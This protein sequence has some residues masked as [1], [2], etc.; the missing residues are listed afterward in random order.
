[1]TDRDTIAPYRWRWLAFAAVLAASV[2][3]LLDST[4]AQVAAPAIRGDLGG[5]YA[6]LQWISAAYSLAMAVVLLTGGR[7]GDIFG[8]RRMLLVGVT[9]FTLSSL[10]G[11]GAQSP[12]VLIGARA[13]QGAFGAIMLPQAFGLIRELFPPAEMPRVWGVFG[14]AMAMSAI[15]GPIVAGLLIGADVLGTGWRMI[16]LVNLPV[17]AVALV[18]GGRF[19]PVVA[20][21]VRSA[22]FDVAG[23]ALAAAGAVMLVYPLVQGRELGWPAWTILMLAGSLPVFAAFG[24]HQV[25]RRR[26]GLASLVEPSVFARRAYT[27]GLAFALVFCAAMGGATLTLTILLQVGLG[28]TPLHAS[29]ATAPLGVG[30]FAGSALAGM[31]MV[32]LGRRILHMGIAIMA[33]GLVAAYL[34]VRQAG[35]GL[36]GWELAAPLLVAGLG[37]GMVFGPLFEVI[38]GGVAPH[39]MGSGSS[40][41]QSV[42]GLGSSLGVAGLG[43]LLFGIVARPAEAAT[44]QPVFVQASELTLLVSIG[45]LAATFVVCF[46]LPNRRNEPAQLPSDAAIERLAA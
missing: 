2:M 8:R 12:D 25:W 4:I 19:L 38:M 10:A 15:L 7:L 23:M 24:A 44:R 28:Y 30:A 13:L 35:V 14:P 16:F 11:A 32:R 20:P 45:L 22:R 36:G 42:N 3:D 9:G 27:S 6:D 41:L 21:V 46:L 43:T 34:V 40:V 33:S 37:M 18:V 31:T 29:L 17:G 39:E 5:S 26:T 1:M